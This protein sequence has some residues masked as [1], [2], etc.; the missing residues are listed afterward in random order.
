MDDLLK[1]LLI[2]VLFYFLLQIISKFCFPLDSN[3]SLIEGLCSAPDGTALTDITDQGNCTD[4]NV[5]SGCYDSNN[6]LTSAN[7]AETCGICNNNYT[8]GSSPPNQGLCET[9]TPDQYNSICSAP[10]GTTDQSVI[11]A[12]E[13]LDTQGTCENAGNTWA[14]APGRWI[15]YEWRIGDVTPQGPSTSEPST[16]EPSTPSSGGT[17]TDTTYDNG[18]DCIGDSAN[19]N[20]LCNNTGTPI[21][22]QGDCENAFQDEGSCPSGGVTS[23]DPPRFSNDLNE[24]ECSSATCIDP[25]LCTQDAPIQWI[26]PTIPAVWTVNT[27]TPDTDCIGSWSSCTV[28]CSDSTY[29]IT[30]PQSGNGSSC[31]ANTGD[32]RECNFGEGACVN[33]DTNLLT[34][35]Q[36]Q[37]SDPQTYQPQTLS[38]MTFNVVIQP[39]QPTQPCQPD[40]V[41][42]D[43]ST[44][45]PIR[46]C[47]SN[48]DCNDQNT[49]CTNNICV[50][51]QT[52]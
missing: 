2:I 20:G 49:Q 4:P 43:A 22:N 14:P 40:Q 10:D 35:T 23:E 19:P 1:F 33:P 50:T 31:E 44:S 29:T 21:D 27:W 9:G 45:G 46:S 6:N 32:T 47:I 34:E 15:S 7:S 18:V 42:C 41:N 30:T 5:W 16:S 11:D 52:R 51:N 24:Q 48:D 26:S 8:D 12:A 38:N 37:G 3:N 39:S 28:D 25:S 17:C 36:T 13:A